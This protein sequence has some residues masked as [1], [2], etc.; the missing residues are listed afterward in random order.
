LSKAWW[1]LKSL[2]LSDKKGGQAFVGNTAADDSPER[3]ADSRAVIDAFLRLVPEYAGLPPVKISFI[4]DA[5]RQQLYNIGS[6]DE[7]DDSF[8]TDIRGYFID[9]AD[10][11]GFHVLDT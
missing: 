8:F 1:R 3:I 7:L 9:Q 6:L 2:F 11:Q 10:A 4:V 5:P